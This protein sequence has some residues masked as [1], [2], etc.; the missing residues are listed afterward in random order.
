MSFALLCCHLLDLILARLRTPQITAVFF[1]STSLFEGVEGEG[2]RGIEAACESVWHPGTSA[3]AS[4]RNPNQGPL[5]PSVVVTSNYFITVLLDDPS[6]MAT[7]YN[8]GDK[9]IWRLNWN[10]LTGWRPCQLNGSDMAN[11]TLL[12]IMS[13]EFREQWGYCKFTGNGIIKTLF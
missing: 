1:H 6:C 12:F 7:T 13:S 4:R 5:D 11:L 10:A 3:G 8:L 2:A 9:K